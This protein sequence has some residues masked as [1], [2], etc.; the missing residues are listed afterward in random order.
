MSFQLG[1]IVPEEKKPRVGDPA[2]DFTLPSSTGESVSLSDFR[3]R[4]EV[5]LFFYPKDNSPA[6]S[7]EACSFRDSYEAFREAGAE[8]LGVS[9]DS[10]KSHTKF[11]ER[12]RLPFPLLSDADGSVRSRYGVARTFGL[13]PGRTTF[14]IDK[15]GIIR[16]E[17]S[18]QLLP[19]KHVSQMLDTLRKLREQR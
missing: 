7:L 16:H 12:F 17:F 1:N 15:Q 5:V 9:A 8:V 4:V 18:S 10:P 6:C 13:F 2:P 14:L 19:L 11:A 3:G